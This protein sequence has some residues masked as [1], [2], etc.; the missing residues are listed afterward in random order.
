MEESTDIIKLRRE[1]LAQLSARGINPYINRF[2]VKDTTG[3][4]ADEF[5]ANSKEELAEI[6]KKC[7]VGGR[8]MARRGHGK[9]TFCH[10][11]DRAG[12]IQV[13]IRH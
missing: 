1:K 6:N 2:K 9:T 12:Q 4:L 11:K 10:L 7:L 8:M 3:L 5:S 13:Y